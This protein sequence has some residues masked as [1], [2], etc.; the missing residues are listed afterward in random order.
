MAIV[1]HSANIQDRDG[2]KLVFMRLIGCF[3]SLKLI[4]ADRGYHGK[5]IG[6]AKPSTVESWK[7]SSATMTLKDLP[8]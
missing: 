2:G 3:P 8:F 1:V 5:L 6:W 4:W 7:S